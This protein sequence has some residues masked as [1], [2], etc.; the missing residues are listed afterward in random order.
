MAK[1]NKFGKKLYRNRYANSAA[2][3]T[4]KGW[5][6]PFTQAELDNYAPFTRLKITNKADE[7]FQV[8]INAVRNV[9]GD[10]A[11][12]VSSKFRN[13][14]ILPSDSIAIIEPEDQILINSICLYNLSATNSSATEVFVEFSNDDPRF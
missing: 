14:F 10:E 8:D 2:I 12:T 5:N 4:T 6:V 13:T 3:N 9:G 7:D 1:L 11:I